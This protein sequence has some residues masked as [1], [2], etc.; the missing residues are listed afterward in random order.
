MIV[1]P[2][3]IMLLFAGQEHDVLCWSGDDTDTCILLL[4]GPHHAELV[5]P[6]YFVEHP[7]IRSRLK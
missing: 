6:R 5:L 1:S 2:F 4:I 3:L 7:F